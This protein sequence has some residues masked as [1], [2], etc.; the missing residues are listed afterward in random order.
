MAINSLL[1]LLGLA[2]GYTS[3]SRAET[4]SKKN[5]DRKQR[6]KRTIVI[7]VLIGKSR[8]LKKNGGYFSVQSLVSTSTCIPAMVALDHFVRFCSFVVRNAA[9]G[10]GR[11][12][13]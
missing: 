3:R 10:S 13:D 2:I 5:T 8:D 4:S 7:R 6:T 1:L 11:Y 12:K 9:H